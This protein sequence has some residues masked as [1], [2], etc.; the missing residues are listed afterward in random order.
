MQTSLP[1]SKSAERVTQLEVPQVTYRG[2]RGY[3]VFLSLP[4]DINEIGIMIYLSVVIV[5]EN[6][7]ERGSS[8][9]LVHSKSSRK[10]QAQH[11]QGET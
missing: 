7:I 2:S 11:C 1:E 6:R 9:S 8:L 4:Y 10:K 3:L 5:K